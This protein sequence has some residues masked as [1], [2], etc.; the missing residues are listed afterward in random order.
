LTSN[1]SPKKP[2]ATS[3]TSPIFF[4]LYDDLKVWEYLDYFAR[5]YK[6][7]P[8]TIAPRVDEVLRLDESGNQARTPSSTAF[9]AA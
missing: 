8:H 4:S 2:S 6:M 5:A 1:S 9:R 3:A 7:E